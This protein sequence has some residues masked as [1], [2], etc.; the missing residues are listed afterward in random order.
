MYVNNHMWITVPKNQEGYEEYN[1]GI[2]HTE[3]MDEFKLSPEEYH[4]LNK[5]GVFRI[6]ENKYNDLYIDDAESNM[7]TADRL[8][9]VYNAINVV[10]GVFLSAIDKAIQYGT[11]ICLDF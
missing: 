5:S 1:I 10:P 11:C 4:K 3:N 6:L 7:I 8:K 9:A 2:E